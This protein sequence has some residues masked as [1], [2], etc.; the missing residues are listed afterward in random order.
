[1]LALTLANDTSHARSAWWLESFS[2]APLALTPRPRLHFVPAGAH[3]KFP[4]HFLRLPHTPAAKRK[5]RGKEILGCDG[6]SRFA[7]RFGTIKI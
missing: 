7:M 6:A 5:E 4:Y 3:P 2:Y 1:M